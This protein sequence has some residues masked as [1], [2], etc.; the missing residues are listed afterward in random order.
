MLRAIGVVAVVASLIGGAWAQDATEPKYTSWSKLELA[1][2]TKEYKTRL[3]EAGSLDQASRTF[4]VQDA[5]PQLANEEN[6]SSIEKVRKRMRDY[7]LADIRN[8]QVLAAANGV[9][10]DFMETLARDAAADPLVRVNAVILIGEL[11]NLE[12]RPW[13]DAVPRLLGL[14]KDPKVIGGVRIA[15]LSGLSRFGAALAA[16]PDT[17]AAVGRA[18]IGILAEPAAAGRPEQDWL[19]G[20]AVALLPP[21]MAG[22][23]KDVIEQLEKMLADDSRSID[24]RVRVAAALGAMADGKSALDVGRAVAAIEVLAVRTLASDVEAAEKKQF[25]EQ[26]RRFVGGND[27][28]A[29]GG[30]AGQGGSP[31]IPAAVV[32]REAWR[33]ITLAGSLDGGTGAMAAGQDGGNGLAGA[34]EGPVAEK[35]KTLAATLRQTSLALDA[36]PTGQTVV[37]SLARLRQ[38]GKKPKPEVSEGDQPAG[39]KPAGEGEGQVPDNETSPFESS[40]FG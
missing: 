17:T 4:L 12:G 26:Y 40:P 22:L 35:A 7:L 24:L 38:P 5:L 16:T 30:A 15:A 1:D 8:P 34:A 13:P 9:V 18:L 25:D 19:A 28:P 33:L 39:E 11:R 14:A 31:K 2:A 27:G 23:P 36:D 21:L 37:A 3:K 29:A 10:A 6:R 20:R 32:R